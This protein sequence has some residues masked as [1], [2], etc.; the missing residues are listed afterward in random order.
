MTLQG[1]NL[2]MVGLGVLGDLPPHP[3][4]PILPDGIH[5]RWAF[6]P[7]LGFPWH[8]YHLF[9]RP[10]RPGKP[11]CIARHWR[12]WAEEPPDAF[13]QAL[14]EGEISSD[15]QL[16]LASAPGGG[17]GIDLRR[18]TYLRFDLPEDRPARSF[19]LRIGFPLDKP[20]KQAEVVSGRKDR[21]VGLRTRLV[22]V[23]EQ[24]EEPTQPNPFASPRAVAFDRGT[25]VA[26][27]DL[28]PGSAATA[29]ATLAA[30]RMDRIEISGGWAVLIDL[31][32]VPVDQDAGEGWGL[33]PGFPYPLCLPT[34]AQGYAC[35]NRPATQAQAESMALGR[36]RYGAPAAWSGARITQLCGVLDSL[37]VNPPAVGGEEMAERSGSW[38]DTLG[39]PE[40][41]VMPDQRPLDLVLMGAIN[42]AV[43][44][45]V[46]LYWI[47]DPERRAA[48]P[49]SSGETA[50]GRPR[51]R[52]AELVEG[53]PG[54]PVDVFRR[55]EPAP[56]A[57]AG[58]SRAAATHDRAAAAATMQE[59]AA[60]VT[61]QDKAAVPDDRGS[62]A[63]SAAYD[64]LL[65]ADHSDRY[66]GE[67]AEA[68]AALAQPLPDD[69]DAWICFNLRKQKAAPLPMP[70]DVAVFALP[71]G[72]TDPATIAQDL[73]SA[74]GLRW[75]IEE[76]GEG[77]LLPGAAIGYHIW[78][79][80]LGTATPSAP[81]PFSAYTHVTASGM[82]MVAAPSPAPG[83]QARPSDWPPWPM[84]KIDGR[85]A[86]GWYSY[87]VSGMDIFGRIGLM[88]APAEWRQWSPEPKPRPWYYSGPASNAQVHPYAVR[89][90]VKTPPPVV[91]GVEAWTLDPLDPDLAGEAAYDQWNALGW[92]NAL[93]A[94]DKPKRA[95]LR[96]RWRWDPEQ[97]AQA[98]RTREFRL[99][100]SPGGEPVP[101]H[102]DP[103]AW[104]Q[105]VYAVDAATHFTPVLGANLAPTGGRQ[106]EVLLPEDAAG[107]AFPG[108]DLEPTDLVPIVY[109][110]VAVSAADDR[111]HSADQSKWAA[112]AWGGRFGNEGR[113]GN[114]AKIF[115]V[116]R[117]PPPAPP[118]VGADDKV[119]ATRADYH[120][121]SRYTFRWAKPGAGRKVHIFRSVDDNLFRTDW[122][123]RQSAG[124]AAFQAADVA[125]F[126][127]NPSEQAAVLAELG[128]PL[129]M[130]KALDWDD[131]PAVRAAY[132]ALSERALRVLASFPGNDDAFV[133]TTTEPLDPA[134]PAH[135]DRAGPDARAPYTPNPAWGAYVAE[136]D[137]K[138][139]NRYFF[140]AAYVN[141]AHIMGPLGPSSPA[142]YLP[143][144]AP[145]RVPAIT[146]VTSGEL[147]ITLEWAHNREPDFAEYRVYRADDE[148]QARDSRLMARVATIARTN[149]DMTK[150]GVAWTD[151]AGLIGGRTYLYAVTGA[152][153][154]GNECVPS[155]MVQAVA[156]DSRLPEPPLWIEMTWLA[157]TDADGALADWPTDGGLPLGA[158]PALRLVWASDAPDPTF[159]VSRQLPGRVLW[160]L[161]PG[162][163]VPAE[164]PYCHQLVVGDADL[165]SGVRYRVRVRS[166]AG[167][168]SSASEGVPAPLPESV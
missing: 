164:D 92:W 44:Q 27:V 123:R 165:A 145:P 14:P 56:G 19:Q 52:A 13:T 6:D 115:R 72:A 76:S 112:G 61:A 77:D 81:P 133:Q 41:P 89:L 25:P 140:R 134:D 37:A 106:Y 99:Y 38:S 55:E 5:L 129:D 163:I 108:V 54:P 23:P 142:V 78:R 4:Q 167:N 2:A 85:L 68:L 67:P 28:A 31:C 79:A 15:S 102:N 75:R 105:R 141:A 143:K 36:I 91:P 30:D 153:E 8:G 32:F 96:V 42:P 9:R 130:V 125:P 7:E 62:P 127:W 131:D 73:V 114:A 22:P 155:A 35:K 71:G 161:V 137:G 116:L 150:P 135:A 121:V 128:A 119:W 17:A 74:A 10:H 90:L 34:A 113:I 63:P 109:A 20:T 64:Y 159:E 111:T 24:V 157:R 149:V 160:E 97:M 57:A 151:S 88:S 39:D 45:M 162:P 40:M 47:D 132:E 94:A 93:P 50:T 126:G 69:V 83:G 139:A 51:A 117:S 87:R 48:S 152:D 16:T 29:T 70:Q 101:G 136:I 49:A 147:S 53:P 46:G 138:A 82:V 95:G 1:D 122:E 80:P 110:H 33:I 124:A 156:V 104:P 148:R 59:K 98:P 146:K 120:G 12:S 43:A 11:I 3:I 154:K 100:L 107:Q 103:L 21:P 168:W 118:L 65:L 60:I 18:R 66:H 86:E 84:H 144:V 166:L 58:R 26:S 158:S